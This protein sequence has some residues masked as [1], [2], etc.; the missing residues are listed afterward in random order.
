MA[1]C[2]LD[3]R[4]DTICAGHNF[5]VLC[6]TGQTCDVK[7]FHDS[8]DS[9][10]DIPIARVA[11]AYTDPESGR[12]YIL[13]INEAL[14]F[15]PRLDHSLINPNQI[16]SFGI[17]V[18]DDPYDQFR[19]LG[20]DHPDL[21][22]P[23]Q[24]KGAMIY[25][26][27][28]VPSDEELEMCLHITLT[29]D[30]TEWDPSQVELSGWPKQKS[31]HNAFIQQMQRTHSTQLICPETDTILDSVSTAMCE[32]SFIKCMVSSVRIDTTPSVMTRN[33]QIGLQEVMSKTRHSIYTPDHVSRVFNLGL[34]K[35][36]T[37]LLVTTQKGVRTAV[38]PIHRRY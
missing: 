19:D 7:G 9:L 22:L 18:C 17:P 5:R 32:H 26:Q 13:V 2:E 14:Y 33:T 23:F 15:G 21:F 31:P 1:N 24:T 28:S 16:R 11:T 38:H 29:D 25:F 10:T 20:I 8:F 3:T 37:T 34:D 4:A 12:V 30:E 35:S 36:K 6:F 27:T